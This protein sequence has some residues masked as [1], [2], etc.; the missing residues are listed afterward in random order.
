MVRGGKPY[1]VEVKSG[2][3]GKLRSLH[4]FVD[5]SGADLAIRLY[6]GQFSMD[7]LKTLSGT[8]FTLLNIPYYLAG[9]LADY[10]NFY[11]AS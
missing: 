10:I 1:P 7:K 5:S 8:P 9:K 4:Q 3:S 11:A 6:G 2:K